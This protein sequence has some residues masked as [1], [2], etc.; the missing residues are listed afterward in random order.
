MTPRLGRVPALDGIR[1]LAVAAVLLFHGGV[2][3]APGGFLG[4][5]VFFVLS[6]FL[7]TTLLIEEM[8]ERGGIGLR[9]FWTRRARRLIPALVVTVVAVVATAHLIAEG[10]SPESVRFDAAAAL[11]YV[12]NWRFIVSGADYFN[13]AAGPSPL[14][15]TWSLAVEE[16]FYVVWPLVALLVLRYRTWLLGVVAV[17]AAAGSAIAMAVLADDGDISR[18]YFGS[19]TRV[20]V[21]LIGAAAAVVVH[22]WRA[23]D[24]HLRPPAWAWDVAG[25]FGVAAVGFAIARAGGQELGLYRGGFAALAASTAIVAGSVVLAPAGG[26]AAVLSLPPLRWLGEIS[27]AAYLWH[28]PAYLLLTSSRTGLEGGQLLAV[29]LGATVAVATA[30]TWLIENPIRRGVVLP[31]FRAGIV[32]PVVAAVLA[33]GLVLDG[34]SRRPEPAGAGADDV[35]A[36]SA[37]AVLAPPAP[38]EPARLLVVG[39]SVAQTLSQGLAA[40]AI[41]AGFQ[42]SEHAVL[43]CGIV[44]GGPFKYFGNIDQQP[45]QCEDWP[46]VWDRVVGERNPHVVLLIVGRWEVM[47]RMYE[48][49]FRRVGQ[50]VFDAYLRAELRRAIDVLTSRGARL[51]IATAPYYRRG[52]RPDGGIWPEDEPWRVDRFNELVR[53]VAAG[54]PGQVTVVDL[55]AETTSRPGRYTASV[56]GVRMR[57][58]GVHFTRPGARRQAP[59]LLPQLRAL[60][61]V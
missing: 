34:V 50:R 60:V 44:R 7:I 8:A 40:E 37:P 20:H 52:E 54:L 26:I 24:E 22:R 14:E 55:N 56:D 2:S 35:A 41:Q 23:A 58:D 33:G 5:D 61:P 12:A 49:R 46:V 31:G 53:E 6:G 4:V 1:G 19:D 48:G 43:G 3:W 57:Y 39:D 30:S 25:A 28:W 16:Q 21:V 47:D 36:V 42:P 17:V 59:W 18:A 51:A 45:P 15:H 32:L 38:G 27:Y 10:R 13:R 9:A 29:R 11:G